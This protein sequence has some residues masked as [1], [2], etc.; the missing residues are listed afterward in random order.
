M[1]TDERTIS[2]AEL[3]RLWFLY[4]MEGAPNNI[5][6]IEFCVSRGVPFYLFDRYANEHIK[7]KI[8]PVT[9]TGL[10]VPQK[11]RGRPRKIQNSE[12]CDQLAGNSP[13]MKAKVSAV[14]QLENGTVVSIKSNCYSDVKDIIDRLEDP[15]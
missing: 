10:P 14:I 9:I 2:D 1:Q 5:P 3:E 6:L 12:A 4:Q 7:N 11:K 13:K 8:E 15:C